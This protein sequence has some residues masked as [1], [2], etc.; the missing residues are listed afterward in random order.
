[1]LIRVASAMAA[2]ADWNPHFFHWGGGHFY[3][4]ALVFRAASALG[5]LASE[6][7]AY[8]VARTLTAVM[9]AATV[10]ITM[11]MAERAYRNKAIT[12]LTGLVFAFTMLHGSSRKIPSRFT[13][14]A[15]ST[16]SLRTRFRT[17]PTSFTRIGH[18]W[19]PSWRRRARTATTASSSSAPA[20]MRRTRC[21]T[22]TNPP[23]GRAGPRRATGA[24]RASSRLNSIS[25]SAQSQPRTDHHD[26]QHQPARV[27][28]RDA[29]PVIRTVP[30]TSQPRPDR[31]AWSYRRAPCLRRCRAAAGA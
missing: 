10:A 12:G 15:D 25:G 4:T 3:V 21:G 29:I 16:T 13:G 6:A 28:R 7:G 11:M 8:F 5:Y 31:P 19:S 20:G 27:C 9:G 24:S 14:S 23:P 17:G 30:S 18:Q 1:M 26:Q 22:P 2:G